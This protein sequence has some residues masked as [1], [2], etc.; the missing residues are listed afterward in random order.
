MSGQ[1]SLHRHFRRRDSEPN[2]RG[3]PK[4]HF[5]ARIRRVT[6]LSSISED[7]ATVTVSDPAFGARVH[8][9]T[10]RPKQARALAIP[11]VPQ[12]AGVRP[13]SGLI[14]DLFMLRA[15]DGRG[16]LAREEGQGLTLYYRLV[17]RVT[18]P[19]DPRALPSRAAILS[20]LERTATSFLRRRAPDRS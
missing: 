19:K 7:G 12:A 2:K 6:A 3:W 16:F 14:Q 8:G 10:I 9:A 15:K 13:S 4:Q 5:W 18:H 11:L 17:K 20:A 1:R